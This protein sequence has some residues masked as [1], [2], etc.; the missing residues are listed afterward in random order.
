[1][2]RFFDTDA[3]LVFAEVVN[4]G[5]ITR[6]SSITGLS[7]ATISRRLSALEEKIGAYV[8]KR[9][10]RG[11]EPTAVGKRLLRYVERIS[12]ELDGAQFEVEQLQTEVAGTLSISIP[13]EFGAGWLGR[14]ISEFALEYPEVELD[15]ATNEGS[16]DLVQEPFDIA[17][18]LGDLP[19]SSVIV[20]KL[21][22]LERCAYASPRYLE[23]FGTPQT[24][25]ELPMHRCIISKL[26]VRDGVSLFEGPHAEVQSPRGSNVVVPNVSVS[27]EMVLSGV[28]IGFMNE[29]LV[30]GDLKSGRLVRVLPDWKSVPMH[31]SAI[32]LKRTMLPKRCRVFLDYLGK[33]MKF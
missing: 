1:M 19:D 25:D 16:V 22:S 9:N 20:R 6:A 24:V 3:L 33:N 8:L 11:I 18:V 15:V 28:G 5:N 31:A 7:S 30:S 2:N 4:A 27:R 21:C 12:K 32:M 14:V 23:Q 10:S 29:Q 17:V 13:T 26:Q